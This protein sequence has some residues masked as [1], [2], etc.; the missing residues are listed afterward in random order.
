[1]KYLKNS[2]SINYGNADSVDIQKYMET[3]ECEFRPSGECTKSI[4]VG[5]ET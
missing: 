4:T 3:G 5:Y 2:S 1:M